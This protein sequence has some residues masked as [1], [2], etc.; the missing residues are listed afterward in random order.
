MNTNYINEQAQYILSIIRSGGQITWSWGPDAFRATEYKK[1]PAL[2]FS[3]NGF[4]HKGDV[5]VA[6]NG[7][8]DIYEIYLL[9]SDD[10][11]A[12]SHK[13]VYFDELVATIDRMVEKNGSDEEYNEK[14]QKWLAEKSQH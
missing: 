1:M 4:V 9:D 8:A 10:K 13:E 2:R 6:L 12:D 5:I 14:R 11:V 7:G 3:V